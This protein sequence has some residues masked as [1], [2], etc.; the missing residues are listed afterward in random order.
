MFMWK[1]IKN[2]TYWIFTLPYESSE[3]FERLKERQEIFKTNIEF[4]AFRSHS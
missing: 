1:I 2:A 3:Y 4:S